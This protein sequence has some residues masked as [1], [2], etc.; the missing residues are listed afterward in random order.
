MCTAQGAVTLNVHAHPHDRV[1]VVQ[2]EAG[3]DGV[4]GVGYLAKPHRVH[5]HLVPAATVKHKGGRRGLK[6]C[7]AL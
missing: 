7:L 1:G 6:R 5:L 2:A 3:L 4:L